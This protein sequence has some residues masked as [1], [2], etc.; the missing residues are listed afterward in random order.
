MKKIVVLALCLSAGWAV[1]A[2]TWS[3]WF[4]QKATQ[5][6]Y[7][8]QQIVALKVYADY[9]AN[10]Y[11]IAKEGVNAV[12]KIKRGDFNLH[13]E[14]FASL[15]AVSPA[16]RKYAK[17]AAIINYQIKILANVR[18]D[19][20]DLQ[21]SKLFT[22]EEIG[23]CHS[24]FQHLLGECLKSLEEVIEVTTSGNT[25]M[26]EA[27]RLKRIDK[28]YSDV[29]DKYAFSAAFGT[30]TGLLALQRATEQADINYSKQINGIK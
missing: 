13:D 20:R 24:V 18:R 26:T 4:R 9:T 5:K 21:T 8:L 16:V 1:Q 15:S 27:E 29:R 25:T 30:E 19:L 3:E 22:L 7:L 12:D 14:F 6:K 23:H 28:I 11:K 2:Q 17:V 10:G